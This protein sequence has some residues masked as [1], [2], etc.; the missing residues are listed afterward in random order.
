[1]AQLNVLG[2]RLAIVAGEIRLKSVINEVAHLIRYKN[3]MNL[4]FS[5]LIRHRTTLQS[6][7]IQ[8]TSPCH[9]MRSSHFPVTFKHPPNVLLSPP[10]P[11]HQ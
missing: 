9:G 4:I 5:G 3:V 7:Q 8:N 6:L 1:M 11:I 10:F 2:R